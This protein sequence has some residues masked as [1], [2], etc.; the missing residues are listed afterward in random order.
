[1]KKRSQILPLTL[2]ALLGG[3]WLAG[4]TAD[5]D[6]GPS[7]A[8]QARL[9][10]N[11]NSELSRYAETLAYM[12]LPLLSEGETG[13]DYRGLRIAYLPEGSPRAAVLTL[14][15][16]PEGTHQHTLITTREADLVIVEEDF[17][18]DLPETSMDEILDRFEPF[19]L[20]SLATYNDVLGEGGSAVWI[21]A[22]SGDQSTLAY[23]WAPDASNDTLAN[24]Q[25]I[26]VL[27]S[28][29]LNE[30]GVNDMWMQIED[31]YPLPAMSPSTES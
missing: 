24:V 15:R 23:R 3:T 18:L 26:V 14:E 8:E 5:S 21:E 1:M 31:A 19:D 17:E 6:A 13:P 20:W 27:V 7:P 29:I 30:Y 28:Q 22:V 16:E 2:V 9:E 4:C 25:E 10:E 12:D 11:F